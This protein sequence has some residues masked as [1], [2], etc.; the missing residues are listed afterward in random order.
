[1]W[2]E[3]QRS[4]EKQNAPVFKAGY[5]KSAPSQTL[6]FTLPNLSV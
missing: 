1:M 5:S 6:D 4:Y 2:K 3:S